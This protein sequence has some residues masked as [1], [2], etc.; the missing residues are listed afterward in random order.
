MKLKLI[1]LS[2][3][4]LFFVSAFY[5]QTDYEKTQTFSKH[6]KQLEDS[7]KNAVSLDE[8]NSLSGKIDNLKNT[9]SSDKAL[10]DKALY[11]DNFTSYFDKIEKALELRRGD[12]TQISEL[13]T[14]VGSLQSQVDEL[15][16]Q[17]QSLISQI[18]ELNTKSEKDA[19]T[20]SSLQKLV[21]QLRNNIQQR[22]EL[23]RD[24]VDRNQRNGKKVA[25]IQGRQQESFL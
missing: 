16:R 5:A 8:L 23:V 21:G 22:D 17:N 15:N 2:F 6:Y 24:L 18:K 12:F 25:C 19:A 9:Y 20:I 10:L 3:L 11:P 14:Q 7:I 1:Y 4:S 13:T